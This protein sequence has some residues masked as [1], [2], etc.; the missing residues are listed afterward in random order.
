MRRVIAGVT[1]QMATTATAVVIWVTTPHTAWLT[2]LLKPRHGFST[3]TAQCMFPGVHHS[4]THAHIC[5]LPLL[6]VPTSFHSLQ[7][8]TMSIPIVE[9]GGLIELFLRNAFNSGDIF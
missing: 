8:P 4:I 5:G 6:L 2:C 3:M 1:P 7:K 9:L